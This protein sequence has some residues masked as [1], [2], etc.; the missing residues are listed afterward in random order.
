M[1]TPPERET[2][3]DI[4][5][6]VVDDAAVDRRLT[7]A[8]IEHRLGWRVE[9][10]ENGAAALAAMERAAPRLVLTDLQMPGMNGL[11]LVTAIRQQYPSVPVVLRTAFGNDD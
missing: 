8:I 7:G 1:A 5:V 9:Y 10:A 6:L 4:T 3:S 11:D 2:P